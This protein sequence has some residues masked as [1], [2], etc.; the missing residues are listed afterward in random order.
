MSQTHVPLTHITKTSVHEGKS[1]EDLPWGTK[2]L[3][4]SH[5]W[6]M[7]PGFTP[8]SSRT[9]AWVPLMSVPCLALARLVDI[10]ECKPQDRGG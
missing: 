6:G 5:L 8:R 10:Q 2:V 9:L 3:L 7:D 4:T 1:I